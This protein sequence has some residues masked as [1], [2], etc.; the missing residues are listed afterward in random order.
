M[1]VITLR[2][3]A[4]LYFLSS[5]SFIVFLAALCRLLEERAVVFVDS[6]FVIT[7]VRVELG[8]ELCLNGHEAI[9]LFRECRKGNKQKEAG[10]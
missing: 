1:A 3:V 5:V 2:R 4:V 9:F 8:K 10:G 6:F 7:R